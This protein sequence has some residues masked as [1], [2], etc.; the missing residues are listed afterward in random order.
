MPRK[1][2]RSGQLVPRPFAFSSFARSVTRVATACSSKNK[3]SNSKSDRT[4][5]KL[6]ANRSSRKHNL[7]ENSSE[8][9]SSEEEEAPE[10]VIQADFAFFDPKPDDFH[11]VKMLLQSYLDD[12]V[13]DLSGFVDLILAQTTVGSVVKIEDDEDEGLFALLTALNLGRYKD[14][15]CITDVRDYLL[16]VCEEKNVVGDLKRLLGDQADHVGL[17]VSQRVTNLPPQLLPHLYNALF[18]EISWAT[19]DEPTKDLRESFR[20][21]HYLLVTRIY[22]KIGQKRKAS[23]SSDDEDIIYVKPEDE[24][25]FELCSWSFTFPLHIQPPASQELKNYR[26]MGLVMAVEADKAPAFREKLRSLIDDS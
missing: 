4:S 14:N 7:K 21:K 24:L 2:R 9:E 10:E 22:K 18:D 1:P 23:S 26:L 11:G 17:V 12:K 3:V 16:K 25:L 13:W 20:F 19:E 15:K 8:S 5:S 6:I